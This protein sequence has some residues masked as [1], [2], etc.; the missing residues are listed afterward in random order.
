MKTVLL[1]GP[2]TTQSGYGKHAAQL[3][4]WLL[5]KSNIDLKFQ[6]LP[7]GNTSWII[8]R[9]AQDGLIGQIHDRSNHVDG[10]L[11]DVTFQLQ[12]PS[13]W[14]P[15]LGKFNV[16]LSAVVETDRCHP[17]WVSACNRM[18][19]I[20]VP[21]E[22]AKKCLLSSGMITV[23]LAIVPEAFPDACSRPPAFEQLPTFST[24]FNFLVFGQ[25]TSLDPNTDRKNTY[26]CV[27]WL[28][29]AFKD[30]P[31]V[32]IILK[33]NLGRN[34]TTD[35]ADVV[36]VLTQMIAAW[37]GKSLNP[38]L[39]LLHGDMSDDEVASLYQHP[40]VK[41]LVSPTRGEGFGLPLLEAASCGLPVIA[42][43]WSAHTEFLNLG[44]YIDLNYTLVPVPQERIDNKIF[45]PGVKW[46]EVSEVDFKRRVTKFYSS[47][48]TPRA[49]AKDLQKKIQEAYSF[50]SIAAQY[51]AVMKGVG[52]EL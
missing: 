44:K 16:G 17:D 28:F 34:T 32:G 22:H 52:V 24:S 27:K 21:S 48:S 42:T 36:N 12:L 31:D 50:S 43:G 40:Q 25:L 37:R 38:R 49:W 7:W 45:V 46:A 26:N 39:H 3:A 35:R 13:E 10:A 30:K 9:D 11:Y 6:L 51:D 4:R 33:T 41:C 1:R 23:P 8:D 15:S 5:Q 18:N 14:D 29:E 2:A 20:I 19:L 47:S